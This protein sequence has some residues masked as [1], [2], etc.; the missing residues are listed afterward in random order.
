MIRKIALALLLSVQFAAVASLAS[1]LPPPTCGP[2]CPVSVVANPA[3][4]LPLLPPPTCGPKCP[5]R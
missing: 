1:A 4:L 5:V 2:K 3:S